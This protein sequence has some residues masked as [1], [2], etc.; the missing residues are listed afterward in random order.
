MMEVE[1]FPVTEI[2]EETECTRGCGT[3]SRL[4]RLQLA[5]LGWTRAVQQ[6]Y[7]AFA[8]AW[9]SSVLEGGPW[10]AWALILHF[11]A[12]TSAVPA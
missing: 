1:V 11:I 2:G 3:Y 6:N 10:N 8:R 5:F 7:C 4:N 9:P 12:I